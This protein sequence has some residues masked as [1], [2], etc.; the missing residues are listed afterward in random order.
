MVNFTFNN[1]NSKNVNAYIKTSDHLKMF[2]RDLEFIRVPGRTGDLIIDNKCF[3]NKD[4]NITFMIFIDNKKMLDDLIERWFFLNYNYNTLTF[5]DNT[6]VEAVVKN[7]D[8]EKDRSKIILD[9]VAD[10]ELKEIYNI[11]VTFNA[12]KVG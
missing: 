7:V 3:K 2:E 9:N 6:T 12:R 5:N 10:S 11:S 4:I 8:I 1:I